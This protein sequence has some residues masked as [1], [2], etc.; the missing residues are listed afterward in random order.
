MSESDH[1]N[2]TQAAASLSAMRHDWSQGEIRLLFERPLFDLLYSAQTVHRAH[3]RPNVVQTSTLLSIKTGACP[4][5]CK[6]CSQSGHYD[7]ELAQEKLMEVE[8]VV[9]EAK[10]AKEAGASRF[11]MGAAW[12]G[13]RE[14]D[15]PVVLE[16]VRQV[17]ALG[18]ETCMTLGML[19]QAQADALG[20]AGL[21]F[22]NHNLDTS[23][24]HYGNIITTRGYQE[25][26]DTLA[27]VRQAGMNVCCGGILG[28]G[29]SREDRVSL[30]QQLANLP[31]HP[32]SVPIN[33]LVPIEGTPM[34]DV[35]PIDPFEF[36]RTVAVARILMPKSIVRLSAGR[37]RMDDALQALCFMAGA[38]SVF[39]GDRLL[40]TNNPEQGK[41]R[42]LF[43]RLDLGILE[44][45]DAER[46]VPVKKAS[47]DT[48]P[49]PLFYDATLS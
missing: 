5:D 24:E 14:K 37:E 38:N 36:V 16:M 44:L 23:P 43:E 47:L 30:L 29:E 8:Q 39:Y 34:S 25:R 22:Y 26:L 6:Y 9:S 48:V 32:E 40:T 28:L 31:E 12:R 33:Q 7:T 10:K 42:A 49:E 45:A 41:D 13:P 4:E 15:M 20:E 21:D 46:D 2:S 35:D 19:D 27:F 11:C 17:R 1:Q 18:M 3:H